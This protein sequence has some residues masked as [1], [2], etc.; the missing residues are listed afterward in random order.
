MPEKK[1]PRKRNEILPPGKIQE[2]APV[3]DA[4]E[5]RVSEEED[6]DI[7]PDEEMEETPP[8]EPPPEGE[9]P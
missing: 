8:Y 1:K 3:V 2:K 5:P 7:I 6:P 9:G 4:E